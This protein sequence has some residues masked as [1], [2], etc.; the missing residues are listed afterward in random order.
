MRDMK[1]PLLR[2]CVIDVV[3]E[4]VL[5]KAPKSCL[6]VEVVDVVPV[7]TPDLLIVKSETTRWTRQIL[8]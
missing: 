3:E 1:V 4:L 8:D 2:Q 5:T 6:P 7:S